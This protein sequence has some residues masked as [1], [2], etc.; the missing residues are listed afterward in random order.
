MGRLQG[1]KRGIQPL[2]GVA[3]A[4][5][6]FRAR[7]AGLALRACRAVKNSRRL[8]LFQRL[9][10]QPGVERAGGVRCGIACRIGAGPDPAAVGIDGGDHHGSRLVHAVH[11]HQQPFVGF[12]QTF[13]RNGT[14]TAAPI[15]LLH[16]PPDASGPE[17]RDLPQALPRRAG[18]GKGHG[19]AYH[20]AGQRSRRC[21]GGVRC[22]D[23]NLNVAH[24]APSFFMWEIQQQNPPYPYGQGGLLL[25]FSGQQTAQ[26]R[27]GFCRLFSSVRISGG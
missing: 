21:H 5:F 4:V 20:A 10:Q 6:A 27:D 12:A 3:V 2:H 22:A 16:V 1:R 7:R 14:Y 24:K 25:P 15:R 17:Y 13:P 26:K 23:G 8:G 11:P 18:K 9:G 19:G